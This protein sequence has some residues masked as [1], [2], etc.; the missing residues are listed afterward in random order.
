MSGLP[1]AARV[2]L[3]VSAAWRAGAPTGGALDEALAAAHAGVDDVV[4]DPRATL[5]RWRREGERFLF[6]ALPRPGAVL[7][8]PPAAPDAVGAALDCG[9]AVLAPTVGGLLVPDL[10]LFG[11]AGDQG[12]QA[13]WTAYPAGPL[14]HHFVEATDAA[15]ASRGLAEAVRVATRRLEEA[16]GIPWRALDRLG[17]SGDAA[18]LPGGLDPRAVE[19]LERAARVVV[20]ASAGLAGEQAGAA[21]DAATSQG[22]RLALGALAHAATSALAEAANACVVDRDA[23]PSRGA[24]PSTDR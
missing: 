6:V 23:Q 12:V 19:V 15:A 5:D 9:E 11:P 20:L 22:R 17:P 14:P 1:L 8:M 3:W 24:Q 4:G 2:A 18:S 21:L 7:G 16:G 10:R 13:C